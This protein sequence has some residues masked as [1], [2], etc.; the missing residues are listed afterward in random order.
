M[1]EIGKARGKFQTLEIPLPWVPAYAGTTSYIMKWRYIIL[2]VIILAGVGSW[3]YF[4]GLKDKDHEEVHYHAGFQIHINGQKQDYSGIEF[5]HI[6]PCKTDGE[7]EHDMSDPLERVH[8][9][10]NVGDVAHVHAE[11]VTWRLL[12][13]NLKVNTEGMQGYMNSQKVTDFLDKLINPYDSLVVFV[14]EP[15]GN[16]E[17]ILSQQVTRGHIVETEGKSEN[18][19]S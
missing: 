15:P 2:L 16:L 13:E 10:D 18:C 14:G 8:L 3:W 7:D 6:K 19:G 4:N 1:V 5:M 17:E 11:G 12:F 9:H